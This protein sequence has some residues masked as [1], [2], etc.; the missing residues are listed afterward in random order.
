MLAYAFPI[1]VNFFN[2]QSIDSHRNTD[3]NIVV[4]NTEKEVEAGSAVHSLHV[5]T[6]L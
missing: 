6:K 2:K 4:V 5:E 1:Y 3:L